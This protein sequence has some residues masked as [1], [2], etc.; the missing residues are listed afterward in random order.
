MKRR[1]IRNDGGRVLSAEEGRSMTRIP[2]WKLPVVAAVALLLMFSM[3]GRAGATVLATPGIA[4]VETGEPAASLLLPYF[5]VDLN[6]DT[7]QGETTVISITNSSATATLAHVAIWT[8]LGI[9]AL[10][11]NVY[12]TGYDLYR[13]N[14]QQLLLTG[15]MP[16]TASAG[17]DPTDTISPKGIFSQDINFASCNG[18]LPY[19]TLPA[20][21]LAGLQAA[22]TGQPSVNYG[23]N[24]GALNHGDRIARGY[25][26]I[27]TV[28]NCSFRFPG[29][30]GYFGVGYTGDATNQNVLF[31]DAFYVYPAKNHAFSVPL[32][33]LT[34]NASDPATS[35]SG[36]YTFYGK[37]DSFT[38]IDNR[39][40]TS[41]NFLH[42]YVNA[43]SPQGLNYVNQG[44]SVIVW[45]DSK[46]NGAIL[47]GSPPAFGFTCGSPPSWYPLGQ[48][49]IVAFDEREDAQ[50][51]SV[52]NP[53]GAQTQFVPLADGGPVPITFPEGILYLDLNTTATGQVSGQTDPAAAQAWVLKVFDQGIGGGG[54]N[55]NSSWEMGS[56]T[57]LL[58]SAENA[59]HTVP[60]AIIP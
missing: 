53:F 40:P 51:P 2:N 60:S 52:S 15:V 9:P 45:R 28:N 39:R 16:Q 7:P 36:D 24:C 34:A 10:E 4:G 22:L 21:Q 41:T 38:A 59:N 37:D 56:E 44:S 35:V 8:D 33:S 25:I 47:A 30:S 58:D 32:V 42:R 6:N 17:Q 20:A 23:G 18:I 55:P 13:L 3:G 1:S 43:G 49:G 57:T 27:D 29:E 26:T 12:L 46:V 19:P 11:F 54:N 5:E 31:G 50:V 48:E 14:L